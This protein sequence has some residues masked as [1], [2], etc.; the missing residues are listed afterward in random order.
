MFENHW[1]WELCL[2]NS[3]DVFVYQIGLT[4]CHRP[5]RYSDAQTACKPA[6]T[7]PPIRGFPS[8]VSWADSPRTRD[9]QVQATLCENHAYSGQNCLTPCHQCVSNL[10][11]ICG[12]RLWPTIVY[13]MYNKPT[14]VLFWQVIIPL[15]S[16]YMFRRM[17]VIIRE[18]SVVCPAELH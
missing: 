6:P 16:S 9:L 13:C 1:Y 15:Y 17:Y 3:V 18:L 7:T 2:V 8:C 5:W 11:A 14:N 4:I 10:T 12:K